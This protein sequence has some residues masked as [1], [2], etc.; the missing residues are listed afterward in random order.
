MWNRK[1]WLG[2]TLLQALLLT[3]LVGLALAVSGEQAVATPLASITIFRP[4]GGEVWDVGTQELILWN[5]SGVPEDVKLE[6]STDSGAHWE[7]I[8]AATSGPAGNY[9]WTIPDDPSDDA[10]VRVT[11]TLNPA[12]TDASNDPFTIYKQY[13]FADS[14]ATVNP[15]AVQ[16]GETVTYTVVLY[17]ETSATMTLSDPLPPALTYVSG[18][19]QVEPAWKNPAQFVGG[20]I[21]WSDLV[22][23]TLPVSLK[24]SAQ[25]TTTTATLVITD[26]IQVSRDGADPVTLSSLLFVNGL[27]VYLPAVLK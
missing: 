24:F 10:L 13:T 14:Y 15:L 16:G 5:P 27:N 20:E 23:S 4:N 3:A 8:V 25:V 6:Y 18:T 9:L 1:I 22:T 7:T 2:M 19:L 21:Q 12:V 17:E 11:S 26:P